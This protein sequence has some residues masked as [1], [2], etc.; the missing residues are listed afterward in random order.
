MCHVLRF[1]GLVGAAA[2]CFN[3]AAQYP[4]KPVRV[5][6]PFPGGSSS[7][8]F[9]R[10]IVPPLAKELGQPV[11]IDN[12]PGADGAIGAEAVIKSPADGYTLFLST[13]TAVLSAPLLK[14][15]PPYEPARDLTSIMLL[16]R[17]PVFL[18]VAPNLPV[19]TAADF[20]AYARAN[21]GKINYAGANISGIVLAE[22][23]NK[24]TG[25]NMVQIPFKS[26]VQT[27]TELMT[28]RVHANFSSGAALPL[29]KEG[30]LKA[31]AVMLD[32]RSSLA[33][34]VPTAAEAGIPP[35]TIT[36]FVG[37]FGPAQLPKPIIDRLARELNP[38][39]QRPDIREQADRTGF[40]T[41]GS[42]PE[43]FAAF[44]VSQ[45]RIWAQ[46]IKD[47]GIQP[48]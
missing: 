47:A 21:Q 31:L 5:I 1:L 2:L 36:S 30:K 14:K 41:A 3:A 43:E 22:A 10:V 15:N 9:A 24:G 46:S 34:D 26:E 38:I 27:F 42:S 6:I 48:E 32:Q 11:I 33:P 25:L 40:H 19:K 44:L 12:R 8:N 17:F 18:V 16:A 39:L 7:D 35:A 37:L 28:G 45:R 23:M 29:V 4:A 13:P 20:V